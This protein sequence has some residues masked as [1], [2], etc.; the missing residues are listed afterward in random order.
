MSFAV[1]L[2]YKNISKRLYDQSCTVYTNNKQGGYVLRCSHL[3][4]LSPLSS[5]M[6][7]DQKN[8]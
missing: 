7:N 1:M 6:P 8:I 4:P 5:V 3:A 2:F